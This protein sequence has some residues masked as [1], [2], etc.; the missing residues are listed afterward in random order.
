MKSTRRTGDGSQYQSICIL[1][2]Q[3]PQAR[4]IDAPHRWALSPACA[5]HRAGAT[6]A[7]Q[8]PIAVCGLGMLVRVARRR[9]CRMFR[10]WVPDLDSP[11]YFVA[12]AAVEL[13]LFKHEGID[14]EFVYNTLQG[15]EL[16]RA[17]KL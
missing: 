9:R 6:F 1:L 15:P 16:M 8:M 4:P 10:I 7:A 5:R 2:G 12:V 17:G 3:A 14:I 11:S 13:G